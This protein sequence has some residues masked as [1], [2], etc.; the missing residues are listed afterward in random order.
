[1]GLVRTGAAEEAWRTMLR[2]MF[3]GEGFTRLP[4]ACRTEGVSPSLAKAMFCLSEDEAHP[5]R[6]LAEQWGCDASYVTALV[7]GLE[8]RRFAERRP[9]PTDRRVK[10]V[11]LTPAGARVK[12]AVLA[13]LWEPPSS[14]S[15]L[16]DEEQEQLCTLLHK[17][18][19]ADSAI[20]SARYTIA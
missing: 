8:E 16:S 1:M 6:D 17:L 14:F 18:A 10:T 5:M 11:V 7:D 15:A 2:L 3:E 4:N 12:A 9:H 20:P 13:R 19:D